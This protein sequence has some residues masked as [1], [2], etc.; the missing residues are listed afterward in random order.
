MA[1]AKRETLWKKCRMFFL[2]PQTMNNDLT[3][4][5]CPADQ[6]KCVVFDEAHKASGN[7]AY[8]QVN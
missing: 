2:T 5:I 3:R 7:Y 1:A 4:G 8:C 6:I